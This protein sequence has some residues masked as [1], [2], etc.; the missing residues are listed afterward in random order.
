VGIFI[1]F[2]ALEVGWFGW[3]AG[4]D[5]RGGWAAARIAG[6]SIAGI[7]YVCRKMIVSI[8]G[9]IY[10]SSPGPGGRVFRVVKT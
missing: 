3:N 9:G 8:D 10:G 1:I 7:V 4:E 6:V 2:N 5:C